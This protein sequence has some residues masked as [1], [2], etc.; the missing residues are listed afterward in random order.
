MILDELLQLITEVQRHQ[1]ELDDMK[2]R[3]LG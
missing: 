3:K 1:S 2:Q